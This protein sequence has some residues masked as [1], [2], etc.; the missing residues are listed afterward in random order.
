ML[1]GDTV[2][3]NVGK[4]ED[5]KS[6]TIHKGILCFYSGY[7][8]TVLDSKFVEGQTNKIDLTEEEARTFRYFVIWLYRGSFHRNTTWT[9]TQMIKLW[10]FGDRREIPLLQNHV[11]DEIRDNV[12]K[13]GISPSVTQVD[14]VYNNTTSDSAL[15][16]FV[17]DVAHR[18]MSPSTV[19]PP[20]VEHQWNKEALYDMLKAVWTQ[21]EAGTVKKFCQVD[22]ARWDLCSY[23]VHQEGVRCSKE[24][25]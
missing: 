14:F 17:I 24:Q 21:W 2:Q 18:R 12:V 19:L 13:Q 10:V 20:Y 1:S 22:V 3:I 15:R 16:R 4:T 11:L 9:F 25:P 23:H 7:F 6:F 8:R 5:Q